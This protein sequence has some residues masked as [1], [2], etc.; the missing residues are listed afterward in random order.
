MEELMVQLTGKK[1]DVSCEANS[2]FRGEVL[3]VK[4]G[5]L[6][7]KDEDA[8]VVYIAINRIAAFYESGDTQS[9]PGFIV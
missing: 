4:N 5:V 1:I 7:L 3:D 6:F 2:V 9:R 8:K